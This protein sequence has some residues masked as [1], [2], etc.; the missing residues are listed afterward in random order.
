MVSSE[1]LPCLLFSVI[2][3]MIF[4]NYLI[5]SSFYWRE[6]FSL[7]GYEGEWDW[8]LMLVDRSRLIFSFFPIPTLTF[9][10]VILFLMWIALGLFVGVKLLELLWSGEGDFNGIAEGITL[11]SC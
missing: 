5:I 7:V 11:N 2:K 9:D 8:Y 4:F 6:E 3:L 1:D 10:G